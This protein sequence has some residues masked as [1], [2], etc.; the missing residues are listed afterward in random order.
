MNSSVV[1]VWKCERKGKG[2]S[3]GN[4]AEECTVKDEKEE[5]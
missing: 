4:T 2:T 1:V 5:E 3:K